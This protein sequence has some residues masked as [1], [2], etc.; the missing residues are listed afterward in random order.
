MQMAEQGQVI[1]REKRDDSHHCMLPLA[2]IIPMLHFGVILTLHVTLKWASWESEGPW[3]LLSLIKRIDVLNMCEQVPKGYFTHVI[4]GLWPLYFK[5]SHWWKRWSR[6]KFDSHCSWGTNGRSEC[7]MDVKSRWICT[8]H[9]IDHVSWS[10]GLNQ[11]PPPGGRPNTTER[12]WHSEISQ[13]LI[14]YI[15][16]CVMT[17]HG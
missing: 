6:S 12:P 7:K 5:H 15:L 9:Q 16:S 13:P 14:Y 17:P 4:K 8:G 11:K 1:E 2:W 3:R 10:L